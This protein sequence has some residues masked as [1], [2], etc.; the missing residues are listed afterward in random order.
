MRVNP[1]LD[2][3][4]GNRARGETGLGQV[5]QPSATACPSRR[6]GKLRRNSAV[7]AREIVHLV[8]G[9]AALGNVQQHRAVIDRSGCRET[10]AK[11]CH[12][13]ARTVDGN[14]ETFGRYGR[15]R[16]KRIDSFLVDL[17]V[18]DVLDV[19]FAFDLPQVA[20]VVDER[21]RVV[22]QRDVDDRSVVL[23]AN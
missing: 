20:A 21:K 17:D 12:Q 7:V 3:Q 15:I 5:D 6:R 9:I 8:V 11:R 22:V 19:E 14:R 1:A 13:L 10:S 23:V 2:L 16:R 18:H 4:V